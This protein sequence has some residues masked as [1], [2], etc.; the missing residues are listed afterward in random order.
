MLVEQH[1]H[2]NSHLDGVLNVLYTLQRNAMNYDR[3]IM[4]ANV[5]INI[6]SVI[7]ILF[8]S[9]DF[10]FITKQ[11]TNSA[12]ADPPCIIIKKSKT[13]DSY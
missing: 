4:R 5:H 8:L 10:Q 2:K 7:N 9:E 3:W 6:L 11:L 13:V 1:V 12:V